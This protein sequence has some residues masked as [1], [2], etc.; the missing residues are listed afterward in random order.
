[1]M[2]EDMT[3]K[4]LNN[5]DIEPFRYIISTQYGMVFREERN[6]DIREAIKKRMMA[7]HMENTTEYLTLIK[8][9]EEEFLLLIGLLT[10]N[11]TYF[12]RESAHLDVLSKHLKRRL[13]LSHGKKPI[14][15]L[16]SAGCSTGEEVYSLAMTL[17]QIPGAGQE[18]DFHVLG[19]DVDVSAV[20]KA[21]SGVFGPYSFRACPED[22][23]LRYFESAAGGKFRINDVVREKVEFAVVNLCT[24]IYPASMEKMD[25]IFYRNVSIYFS[26]EWQQELFSRLAELLN[27][28]GLLFVSSTEMLNYNTNSLNVVNTNSAFYYKKQ[29]SMHTNEQHKIPPMSSTG[30]RSLSPPAIS[31]RN[32]VNKT[33]GQMSEAPPKKYSFGVANTTAHHLHKFDHAL[34]MAQAKQYEKALIVLEEIIMADPS[35]SKGYCLQASILLNQQKAGLAM[36]ICLKVLSLDSFCLEAY[37]LLGMAARMEGQAHEALRRFKEA[38][39]LQSDCWLAHF[40]MAEIFQSRQEMLLAR[41]E[42]EIT[43][44]ILSQG[45]IEKHGLTF[46]PIAFQTDQ[47]IQLC[48]HHLKKLDETIKHV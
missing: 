46:F 35:F 44:K 6:H 40:Y 5:L 18:W 31:Q 43:E 9:Q 19:V 32:H 10:V 36:D 13:T 24:P 25:I 20:E 7:L 33:T 30:R 11:E 27:A 22:L 1:M 2:I 3:T 17:L 23:R 16:L 38:V 47:F 26:K 37:L 15:R 41:R 28:D 34:E 39:Y 8:S 12:F 42:Y 4:R 29:S 48:Q 14:F 45:T 21:R